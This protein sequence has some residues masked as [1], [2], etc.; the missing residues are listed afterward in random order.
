MR[1]KPQGQRQHQYNCAITAQRCNGTLSTGKIIVLRRYHCINSRSSV[2]CT[3][4]TIITNF[5]ALGGDSEVININIVVYNWLWSRDTHICMQ[6]LLND[7]VP[8]L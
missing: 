7:G 4:I 1:A 3:D 2:L 8:L 6:I 5:R